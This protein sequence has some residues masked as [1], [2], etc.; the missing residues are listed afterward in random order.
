MKNYHNLN[1]HT[2]RKRI[3]SK[4]VPVMN[5]RSMSIVFKQNKWQF[6]DRNKLQIKS[7][8]LKILS[9]FFQVEKVFPDI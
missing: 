9:V 2:H 8:P 7:R 1:K 4:Q 6:M 5:S 3:S